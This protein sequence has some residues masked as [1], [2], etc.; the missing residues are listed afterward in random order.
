MYRQTQK[1]M[2]LTIAVLLIMSL[3]VG[4]GASS[5]DSAAYES[6]PAAGAPEMPMEEAATEEAI[7][8]EAGFDG[9]YTY[10]ED[11]AEEAAEPTEDNDFTEKI[12]YSGYLYVETTEFD[13]G[14]SALEAMVSQYGGFLE[15]SDVNGYTTT[16][17][18]GA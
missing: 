14:L 4:C 17:S 16:D 9:E 10:T 11:T 3:F 15:S 2:A 5:A 6:A 12:I 8:E 18:S 1:W 13:Q 7:A